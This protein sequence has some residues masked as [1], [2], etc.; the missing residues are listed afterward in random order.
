MSIYFDSEPHIVSATPFGK[1][2]G[3]MNAGGHDAEIL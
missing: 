1:K 2:F 3:N